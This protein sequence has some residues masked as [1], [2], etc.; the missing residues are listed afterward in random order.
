MFNAV[1][2][3]RRLLFFD[4]INQRQLD[5]FVGEFAMCHT[6]PIAD[7]LDQQ[8]F[9][10]PLAELLLTKLQIVELTAR[11][12]HDIWSLCFHH[13]LVD[14]DNTGIEIG[15]IAS[16]CG[17]DWGLW[18]TCK[19]T[20][21]HSISSLDGQGL[22]ATASSLVADRLAALSQLIDAAP[23]TTS[24]RIRSRLGDR[25]RWYDQPEAEQ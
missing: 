17:K 22:N 12:L 14:G 8:A 7:R 24:W 3:S 6:I 11:D 25:V 18:R 15:V 13:A 10:I 21:E 23:K 2:G 19:G 20:I 9:T 5:V 1:R 4:E 16:L